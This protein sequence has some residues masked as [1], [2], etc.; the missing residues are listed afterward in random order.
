[1]WLRNSKT[2]YMRNTAECKA[3]GR[4]PI[5]QTKFREGLNTGNF[6]EM[7]QMVFAIFVTKLGIS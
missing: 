6:K 4:R 5:S 3:T 1:M 2:T 7:L